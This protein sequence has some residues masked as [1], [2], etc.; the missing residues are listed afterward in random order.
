MKIKNAGILG[1]E[2]FLS[3]FNLIQASRQTDIDEAKELLFD[4]FFRNDKELRDTES[5]QNFLT[6][7]EELKEKQTNDK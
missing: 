7:Y 5:Y 6:A 2:F 3:Y 1:K 4:K